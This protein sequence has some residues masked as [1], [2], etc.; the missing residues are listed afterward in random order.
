MGNF[1]AIKFLFRDIASGGPAARQV[2]P[3]QGIGTPIWLEI[4]SRQIEN[5]V[6]VT[7]DRVLTLTDFQRRL[8]DALKSGKSVTVTA[9]TSAGKSFALQYYLASQLVGHPNFFGLFVVP[10][11]SLIHQVSVSL[12]AIGRELTGE[13][14]PVL[15]IPQSPE[16]AGIDSGLYVLTQERLQILI[17]VAPTISFSMVVV[18][19]A[20]TVAADS[21][22]IILQTVIDQLRRSN[23]E[24]QFLFSSPT[25]A[26]P[27][28]FDGL[29]GLVQTEKIDEAESPVAQNLIFLDTDPTIPDLV[30]VEAR[31]LS[32]REPIGPAQVPIELL[33]PAQTLAALSWHFG[34]E[35]QSLVY[36][37]SQ[38]ASEEVASMIS[39]LR[40]P[41]AAQQPDEVRQELEE[42]SRF[43]RE[44]IHRQYLLADTVLNGVAF[45][46][47]QIP[48]VVRQAIEDYFD[49]GLLRFLV[50]TSTLLHGVN[51]PARNLFLLDPTKDGEW[52]NQNADAISGPEFWNLA[53]R[54]GRLG[55]EFEGNV[56]IINQR[57]WRSNPA[58]ESPRQ[59]IKSALDEHVKDKKAALL[60]FIADTEHGSG[61]EQALESAFVKLFNE[62]RRGTLDATLDR[63][64][65]D[66]EASKAEIKKAVE[67]ALPVVSVPAQVTERHITVSVY[68]Q[69]EMYSYLLE[70]IPKKGAQV[71]IPPHPLSDWKLA[72][73]NI[74]RLL[75]RLHNHFQHLPTRDRSHTYFAG[76]ALRW[77][78]GDPL[79]ELIS[80][81]YAYRQKVQKKGEPNIATVIRSV[82][83]DIESD[84]RFRYVKFLGCYIDILRQALNDTGNE[85]YIASIPSLPLYLE[86]GASSKTMVSLVGMGLSRTTAGVIARKAA[87]PSMGPS[88]VEEW[89]LKQ[90][91]E[92]LGIS[93]IC[94]RE[95]EKLWGRRK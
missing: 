9:P 68:R 60:A 95:V 70:S 21:R 75:K 77:M 42:L 22:G 76:L 40:Q 44:H 79:P 6:S 50:S 55:R 2:L 35:D 89:L 53:G 32:Q 17:E 63:I 37:G 25:V 83:S 16:E 81:A 36:V 5:E 92:G 58:D 13:E 87:N 4:A 90:N 19:E 69:Q 28:V 20:Q 39:Q 86:L 10:T 51:L 66:D 71:Y 59:S 43:L 61:N 56:F 18:D 3:G 46:Y 65:G 84:L 23:P 41:A 73:A 67:T 7:E 94:I 24:T 12:R 91:L 34:R 72:F 57:K 29:F 31:I 27:Q 85:K 8:W 74:I 47:G 82:M 54:A 11:R 14:F 26:N 62:A 80:D 49:E 78:R 45:H 30:H 15:T 93:G 1:P 88:E 48:A 33:A 38:A 64:Y 52:P